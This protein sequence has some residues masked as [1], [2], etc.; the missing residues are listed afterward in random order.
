MKKYYTESRRKGMSCIIKGRKVNGIGHN[1]RRNC[2]V[3]HVTEGKK[4]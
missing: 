1:W 3:A 4:K 2:L